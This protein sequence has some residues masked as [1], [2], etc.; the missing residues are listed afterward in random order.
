MRIFTIAALTFLIPGAQTT[1]TVPVDQEPQHK[2]VFKNEFVR[3]LDAT[4]PPGYVTLNHAHDIDNVSVTIATGREG[5]AA[6]RGPGRA[7]FAK[8]GYS[9][10]VT[11]SGAAVMRFIVVEIGKTDRPGSAPVQLPNHT[12]ESENDRVRIYRVKLARGESLPAHTHPAGWVE[13]TVAGGAGSGA[14]VWHAAGTTS[15]LAAAD[16]PLEIVEVEPK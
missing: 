2:V 11:N 6:L 13:V 9:H 7:S 8:G 16:T 5:D 15:T 1:T 3:V 4:L 12:L 14:S 10:S